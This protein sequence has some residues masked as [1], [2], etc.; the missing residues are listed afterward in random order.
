MQRVAVIG[1]DAAEVELVDEMIAAGSLP[2]LAR[3]RRSGAACR[4]TSE[5]TWRSGRVWETLLTGRADFP[6][7]A[8]FDPA[9]YECFQLGSRR[10]TPF[11]AQA[12]GLRVVAL[13]VPYMSLW[14]NVPGAQVIWG[15]HDAGYPR[16]SR[17]AGL[18]REIDAR[19]GVHPA[20]HND[21]DCAWHHPRAIDT[22]ADALLLGLRRRIDVIAWL[23][24]KFPDWNLFMTVLSEAHSAGEMFWHGMAKGHPLERHATANLARR[25]LCEVYRELDSSI[26]RIERLLPPDT[27]LVVC[28]VHGMESNHYDV[29]S[30]VLLPELLYREA[31][32]KRL[33]PANDLRPWRRRG[34]PPVLPAD[35]EKWNDA[36]RG[37]FGVS[38]LRAWWLAARRAV[39]L[40]RSRRRAVEELVVPI[41]PECEEPPERIAEPRWKL[42]WQST[43]WYR[44]YW[45]NMR[46]FALPVFYDGR[47]RI[48]LQGREQSGIVPQKEYHAA[49]DAV[50]L[51]LAEC[52]N[53]R[54][55]R[56][57]LAEI[58]RVRAADP[59]AP[60][61]PD[62]DLVITWNQN[63]DALE[64]PRLGSIGPIPFR[65]TGGH[66]SRGFASVTGPGIA[67]QDL[68][69][70]EALDL[71]PTLLDLLGHPC[72]GRSLLRP[73]RRAA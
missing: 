17:P 1:L 11:Y 35:H 26:E 64:H 16:A 30:M 20:F 2:A 55:G 54:D 70:R 10:Q 41:R 25:R 3:L 65:R 68:G 13:D 31:T 58:E 48:N 67:A 29:P 60:D 14:H 51:L 72:Q 9:T 45:A 7:A 27:T 39:G 61:G 53:P 63:I 36:L 32:G 47:V 66:T 18:V 6:G 22:L 24:A 59:L 4:L 8:V 19:F 15:G 69:M 37:Q 21:F 50:E 40:K 43:C 44:P 71:T 46:A 73:A 57:V 38:R 49:C 34:C 12:P 28:S 23:L 62:A 42:D 5:A 33:L 52:R 56:P